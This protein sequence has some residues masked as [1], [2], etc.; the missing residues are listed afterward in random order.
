MLQAIGAG[1][2][3]SRACLELGTISWR[4]LAAPIGEPIGAA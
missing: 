1:A 3:A 4:R 2:V